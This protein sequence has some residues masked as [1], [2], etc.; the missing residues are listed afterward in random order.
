MNVG[1]APE[2]TEAAIR[3]RIALA[4][5][6]AASA[7]TTQYR[8]HFEGLAGYWEDVLGEAQERPEPRRE[9][10]CLAIAERDRRPALRS[11]SAPRNS[12]AAA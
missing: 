1:K 2:L 12:G 9:P 10:S 5:R 7:T 6:Q 8:Q 4:W 3:G 11:K